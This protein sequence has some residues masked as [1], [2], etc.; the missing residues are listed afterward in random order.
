MQIFNMSVTYSQGIERI[1]LNLQEGLISKDVHCHY[2]YI[3]ICI[4]NGPE[5][6]ESKMLFTYQILVFH[7]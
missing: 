5:M 1:H 2:H 4:W 6:A 7:Q 3:H